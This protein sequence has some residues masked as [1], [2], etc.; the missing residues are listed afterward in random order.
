MILPL[1]GRARGAPLPLLTLIASALTLL[2]L[3]TISTYRNIDRERKVTERFLFRQGL[4]VIRAL[5]A[6]A[7]TGMM[8]MMWQDEILQTLVEEMAQRGKLLRI[9]I[10]EAGG[11]V[12]A[13]SG[14]PQ[15]GQSSSMVAPHLQK[16]LKSNDPISWRQGES[17]WVAK[18]FIP[19]TGG[20]FSRHMHMMGHWS[21]R[22]VPPRVALVEMDMRPFLEAQNRDLR[23]AFLMGLILLALGCASF[24]F[25]FVVQNLHIMRRAL[26][27]TT[28]YLGHVVDQMP[29]GLISLSAT[30]K[31][32]RINPQA[33]ALLGLQRSSPRMTI[34]ALGQPWVDLFQRIRQGE[35]V[36][37]Q[38]FVI[39][40]PQGHMVPVAVS[41][42][43]VSGA[44]GEDLGVVLLIRDLRDIRALQQQVQRSERLASLG[45]LAAGVAHE[46][47]NPLSSIKGL[48]QLFK[49]RSE[50]GSE[51]R[52]FAEVMIQ[53]VDRLNGV[54]S[55][56]LDFA[57]PKEPKV[58]IISPRQVAQRAFDLLSRDLEAKGIH[59]ELKGDVSPRPIDPHQMTQ[60]L[61]NLLLNAM[62]A[63]PSGGSI[64]V[65][66]RELPDGAWVIVVA[67]SGEGIPEENIPR[68]FDPFFTTKE[69]GTGL[70]LAIVHKIV[71]N[72][73]GTIG[74]E[75]EA[76]RGSR[77][78]LTFGRYDSSA[79]ATRALYEHDP[80][81][82]G[83]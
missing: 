4:N 74:V 80:V 45:K 21:D 61:I 41:G 32:L 1:K 44:Q 3:L 2:V 25:I 71:E 73:G 42:S 33:M 83:N 12:V 53:E 52:R 26:Q 39:R 30:G 40:D 48:A 67:D 11:R 64:R 15:S 55:N 34:E 18:R 70:G 8:R 13:D 23:H 14:P 28:S 50:E 6:G 16:A 46:I 10:L 60:A 51:E 37:Q 62:E 9:M 27:S 57:R 59:W 77:F 78:I 75:S 38:E 20:P 65:E 69:G 82:K 36:H 63:T 19:M 5:E 81:G 58:S 66:L 31:V 47:R 79:Q 56:L 68:L 72:H 24:Y 43:R 49:K 22:R 35:A 29:D 17:Y 54:I 7:R 76:G